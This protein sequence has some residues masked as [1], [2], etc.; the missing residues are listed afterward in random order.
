MMAMKTGTVQVGIMGSTS[1]VEDLTIIGAIIIIIED[2]VTGTIIEVVEVITM[3]AEAM[4]EDIA[5]PTDR[6]LP[7]ICDRTKNFLSLPIIVSK[8]VKL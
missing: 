5:S 6:Y 7:K 4:A 3:V 8:R 1:I 2:I